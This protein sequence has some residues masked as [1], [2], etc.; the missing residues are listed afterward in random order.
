MPCCLMRD[1][2]VSIRNIFL[3]LR[4]FER[5]SEA[6]AVPEDA[7]GNEQRDESC[8][9]AD[10]Q[11]RA[12]TDGADDLRRKGV[13]E[14]VND[15]EIRPDGSGA[16]LRRNRIHDGGIQGAGVEKEEEFRGKERRN[17]PG[18]RAKEDQGAEGQGEGD[19]PERRA[20]RAR[21]DWCAAR[22]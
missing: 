11:V 21:G 6:G 22:R 14:A 4:F 1:S 7:G 18:L 17:G 5:R 10:A 16:D 8:A 12:V 3:Q 13:A 2:R 19:A 20:D 15:E 9:K